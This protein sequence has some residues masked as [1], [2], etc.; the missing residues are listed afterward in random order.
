ML[1]AI[2]RRR[3]LI[4]S[5]CSCCGSCDIGLRLRLSLRLS[6]R[7]TCSMLCCLLRIDLAKVSLFMTDEK[8]EPDESFRTGSVGAVVGGDGVVI[9]TMAGEV[10][11]ARKGYLTVG[12]GRRKRKDKSAKAEAREGDCD[13]DRSDNQRPSE[14]TLSKSTKAPQ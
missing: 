8:V 11:R 2:S 10:I 9:E 13:D 14:E 3:C 7:R 5:C 4:S 6:F 1:A 12:K